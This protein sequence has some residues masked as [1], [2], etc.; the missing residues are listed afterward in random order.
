MFY[1]SIELMS[2]AGLGTVFGFWVDVF[3]FVFGF[4]DVIDSGSLVYGLCDL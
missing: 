4:L 1:V 2:V 3:G